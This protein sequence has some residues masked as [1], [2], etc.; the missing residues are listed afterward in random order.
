MHDTN[1]SIRTPIVYGPIVM[2]G[3]I[4]AGQM[5]NNSRIMAANDMGNG[6]MLRPRILSC[7]NLYQQRVRTTISSSNIPIGI[8]ICTARDLFTFITYLQCGGLWLSG[9]SRQSV[10][11]TPR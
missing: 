5:L 6:F 8:G 2:L 9:M 4:L 11:G 10:G 7:N 1:A 3:I